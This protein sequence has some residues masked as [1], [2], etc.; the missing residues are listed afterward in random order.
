MMDVCCL[1]AD[2]G[3]VVS[4]SPNWARASWWAGS[5]GTLVRSQ[6]PVFNIFTFYHIIVAYLFVFSCVPQR[7]CHLLGS[8]SLWHLP[9]LW[10]KG[11]ILYSV[12]G[13]TAGKQLYISL[14]AC[15]TSH[16]VVYM[17][18]KGKLVSS[19][20]ILLFSFRVASP[21]ACLLGQCRSSVDMT[22]K[23]PVW[24]SALN[25]TWLSQGQRYV[26]IQNVATKHII[27]AFMVGS[28][29][30]HEGFRQGSVIEKMQ[31]SKEVHIKQPNMCDL[32]EDIIQRYS[33]LGEFLHFSPSFPDSNKCL[34]THWSSLIL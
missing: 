24:P 19:I 29:C 7:C 3:T 22:R 16:M 17:Q 30:P 33:N 34:Q 25:Q 14:P 18:G 9:H 6:C 28:R 15:F 10:F 13:S 8:G 21:V 27:E 2:T 23:S 26:N 5:A 4:V 20:F 12:A 31:L 11:H 1:V 32:I